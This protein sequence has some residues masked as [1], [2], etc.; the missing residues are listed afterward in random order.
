MSLDWLLRRGLE[1]ALEVQ[2]GDFA[3]HR[4]QQ[5][6][7]ARVRFADL[8]AQAVPSALIHAER[9]ESDGAIAQRVEKKLSKLVVSAGLWN[10]QR[11]VGPGIGTHD[12]QVKTGV[13][14]VDVGPDHVE[15][16]CQSAPQ[17]HK[18]LHRAAAGILDA[19]NRNAAL[20][21]LGRRIADPDVDV[22]G[23][24]ELSLTRGG[25]LVYV[26]RLMVS[27]ESLVRFGTENLTPGARLLVHDRQQVGRHQRS[28]G[29]VRFGRKVTNRTDT[30]R[31]IHNVHQQDRAV[32]A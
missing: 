26:A 11:V 27:L 13:A 23:N 30:A 22:H 32:R 20:R 14:G 19:R 4:T 12:F 16:R 18:L 15:G 29:G 2:A 7:V 6:K 5:S 17:A 1:L 10:P 21:Q 31:L 28:K 9:R 25:N 3:I 8:L 24:R